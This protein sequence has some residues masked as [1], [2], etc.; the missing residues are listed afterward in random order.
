MNRQLLSINPEL[1]RNIHV[2]MSLQRRLIMPL[3]IFLLAGLMR[4]YDDSSFSMMRFAMQAFNLVTIIWGC[5]NI[6]DALSEE[7]NNGTWDWQRMSTLGPWKLTI[8]KLFG[9]TIYNWY[10]GL[11]CILI[12]F[13]S[14]LSAKAELLA[15]IIGIFT[16]IK[17]AVM[18]HALAMMIALMI[19]RNANERSK[20]KSIAWILLLPLFALEQA[21][22]AMM[23][24]GM[25]FIQD[26]GLGFRGNTLR[27]FSWYGLELGQI[28]FFIL[29]LFFTAW[30]VAGVYRSMRV[31]LQY[32]N[33][34]KWWIAFMISTIIYLIGF[35]FMRFRGDESYYNFHDRFFASYALCSFNFFV[36]S[37]ILI[38]FEPIKVIDFR[39]MGDSIRSKNF[40]RLYTQL[41]LWLV[42]ITGVLLL[43]L[44]YLVY[45]SFSDAQTSQEVDSYNS[46][47]RAFTMNEE[48]VLMNGFALIFFALRD[49]SIILCIHFTTLRKRANFSTILYLVFMHLVLPLLFRDISY[50]FTTQF[51]SRPD[52][53]LLV[54]SITEAAVAV[55]ILSLV[56][57][58][59]V[60][61]KI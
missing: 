12:Y 9:S 58:E 54:T 39:R 38:Y 29:N 14:A 25:Q 15:V 57:R 42:T 55:F 30:A 24:L 43:A 7:Y 11:F 59:K 60:T 41:P 49:F 23:N 3:V 56:W 28:S 53:I 45:Y 33:G 2:E 51:Y 1:A 20:I 16:M 6:S 35:S 10:G 36:M 18:Y 26:G 17:S 40:K 22:T 37:Y 13:F 52:S 31:E 34:L 4:T 5:K 47:Y 46:V 50:L 44:L 21:G 48:K 8:G 27:S 19:I 32:K 61:R